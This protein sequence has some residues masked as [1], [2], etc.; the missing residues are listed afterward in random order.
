MAY[1]DGAE[2]LIDVAADSGG[3]ERR[4]LQGALVVDDVRSTASEA[5]VHEAAIVLG[6]LAGDVGHEGDV[7]VAEAADLALSSHPRL[8]RVKAK[9]A[10]LPQ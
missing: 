10:K 9:K 1:L 6:D 3:V 2:D 8:Q 7:E 5:G 4:V